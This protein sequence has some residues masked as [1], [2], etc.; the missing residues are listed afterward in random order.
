[1]ER[2]DNMLTEKLA[3]EEQECEGNYNFYNKP[4][5]TKGFRELFGEEFLLIIFAAIALINETYENP[6]YL[7]VLC[8]GDKKFWV[9]AD[10]Q[11]GEKVEDYK[12]VEY[13]YVTFLLPEEY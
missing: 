13:L 12:D 11:K 4:V 6:D 8:Y 2:I 1:V 9:I 5:C 7:Q 3:L 10:F